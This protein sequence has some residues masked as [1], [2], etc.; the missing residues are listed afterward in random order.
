[1]NRNKS[2]SGTSPT[3]DKLKE[4]PWNVCN[5]GNRRHYCASIIFNV[6]SLQHKIL[7]EQLKNVKDN[8]N[9]SIVIVYLH[10]NIVDFP[11]WKCKLGK[12]NFLHFFLGS[13]IGV[14]MSSWATFNNVKLDSNSVWV[15]KRLCNIK[16]KKYFG[17][18]KINKFIDRHIKSNHVRCEGTSTC[19]SAT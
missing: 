12:D 14:P 15:E 10:V 19:I 7:I 18:R 4:M 6:D 9:R 13:N 5:H 17:Y 3:A 11:T 16:R 2:K 8:V 1:M